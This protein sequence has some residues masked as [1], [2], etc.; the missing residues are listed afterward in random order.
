[1]FKYQG[2]KNEKCAASQ[3]GVVIAIDREHQLKG[4]TMRTI[5]NVIPSLVFIAVTA[6][7]V[8][9]LAHAQVPNWYVGEITLLE[10]WRNGNVAFKL[11]GTGVPCNGQFI[12]NKSESGT[13]NQ[14]AALIA[15][16]LADRTVTVYSDACGPAEDYGSNYAQVA[17]VYPN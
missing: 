1:L 13:K 6:A 3:P 14:Y 4:R 11:S 9:T 7:G 16:K 8:C 2:A 10:V 12:L 5:R 17:Y 15:A